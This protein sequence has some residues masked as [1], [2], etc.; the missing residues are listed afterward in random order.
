[1][2]RIY[3]IGRMRLVTVGLVKRARATDG[4]F[5]CAHVR[6]HSPLQPAPFGLIACVCAPRRALDRGKCSAAERFARVRP[7]TFAMCVRAVRR[8]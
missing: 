3:N 5:A 4:S 8:T 1:M 7:D 2:F 6:Q